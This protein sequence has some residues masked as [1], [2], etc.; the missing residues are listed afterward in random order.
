M[1]EFKYTLIVSQYY[2]SRH[3]FIVKHDSETFLEKAKSFVAELEKYKRDEDCKEG[4]KLGDLIYHN[5]NIMS[6]RYNVND[7]GDIYF[8]NATYVNALVH[9]AIEYHEVSRRESIGFKGKGVNE[10]IGKHHDFWI[11]RGIL[12]KHFE[13][14]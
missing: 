12:E 9:D 2:H 11:V 7:H 8:I 3:S 1:D 13:I 14:A 10:S 6:P 5:Q 4:V